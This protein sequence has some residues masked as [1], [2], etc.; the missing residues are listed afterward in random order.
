[1]TGSNYFVKIQTLQHDRMCMDVDFRVVTICKLGT[2]HPLVY[3]DFEELCYSHC[4]AFT[5]LM[6]EFIF[7]NCLL[8]R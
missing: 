5:A 2:I 4:P 8:M 1:M 3:A 6:S 7:I